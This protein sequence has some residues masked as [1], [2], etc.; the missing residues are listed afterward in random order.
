MRMPFSA[1]GVE[2]VPSNA[3]VRWG[4]AA[5]LMLL[6]LVAVATVSA[7]RWS[8]AAQDR[9]HV[10]EGHTAGHIVGTDDLGRDRAV[11]VSVALLVALAGAVVASTLATLLGVGVGA[12]AAFAPRPVG[13]MLMYGSDLLLTLPWL[14]LL[15]IVRSA[16]PLN[17]PP[18][19]SATVTFLLLGALGWP[20]FARIHF[21]RTLAVRRAD[22]MLQARAAGITPWR[23]A[24][25]HVLPHLHPGVVGAVPAVHTGVHYR[26]GEPRHAGPGDQRA[27]AVVGIDAVGDEE[28]SDVEQHALGLLSADTAGSR[29]AAVG[30][31][32]FPGG[33]MK[34][35]L[36][37]F[38][39]AACAPIVCVNAFAQHAN[40]IAWALKSE[41]K[42]LD[43]ALTDDQASLTVRYLTAGVL[44]RLNR[45][46]LQVEPA[47][48]ERYE[49][50]ADG[51]LMTL[52]LRKGLQFSD[53]SPLTSTDVVWSL[54]RVLTPATAA[55]VAEEF[56]AGVTVDAP[57]ALTV[58]VHLPLRVVTIAQ[59]MDEV[60]IEPANRPSSGK[61]TSG[62]FTIAEYKRGESLRLARNP[63]YWR[64]D[65]A[66]HALPYLEAVRLDVLANPETNELRFLRGQYQLIE[67]VTADDFGPLAAKAA[68]SVRDLGP[69][70]N[71]EQ[72]WFNEA[73]NAPIPAY[74][75]TWFA[76]RGFRTAV[77]L[78][79]RRSDMVRIAYAG[80][81]TAANDFVSPAN[82]FWRDAKL[83]PLREDHATA[84]NALGAE[85][86]RMQG[87]MLVDREGHPV[88]FSLLT[89]AGNRA[90]EKMA[91]L[92]Q[93]DLAAIGMQVNVVTLDFPAL[94]D[95]LMHTQSY[96]AALL[97]L[98][99]V[100][101][102]PSSME[103]IWLSS[104]PNHQFNPGEKTPATAWESEIDKLM[105]AQSQAASAAERK[106]DVDR[107]QEIV[108]EQQPFI[109]LV[110][111][112]SLY[113]VSPQL[114]GVVL[115]SLQP[116][117]VS[118]IDAIRWKDL[119]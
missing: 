85:G 11:R 24:R 89:N 7:S 110:H 67:S 41:P 116:G 104:S 50:S 16:L 10:L 81:A 93:Q 6:V 113:A 54:Q 61:V 77:S 17:L 78:A 79:L 75:K 4:A 72:M 20:A 100:E 80:H 60:A 73:A 112:N 48:A 84:L 115:T 31:D 29:F 52:H 103:N 98:T 26:G 37:C 15:M 86:F 99:N 119:H 76:N 45:Q 38:V 71:T 2:F 9:E 35:L 49:L 56:G 63:H 59:V 118:N 51:K 1:L 14:F 70:L 30:T 107:V 92:I 82:T 114:E 44:L 27:A 57:D 47:L 55:P 62:P 18:E 13:K 74:E 88:K 8:Y 40:E 117:V 105:K 46:T 3:R 33:S 87:S 64:H 43:P 108:A 58:R 23:A 68:G 95:R 12:T 21:A 34:H 19:A 101:P 97:G 5:L 106:R 102:D 83:P 90:R 111:P 66:G 32:R 22:W 39:V 25:T 53:G 28:H 69:S 42:T 96:E 109:Y 91:S 36:R 94:I 65:A